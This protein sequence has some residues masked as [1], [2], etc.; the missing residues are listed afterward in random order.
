MSMYGIFQ[1]INLN[2]VVITKITD[3]IMTFIRCAVINTKIT[4]DMRK[5]VVTWLLTAEFF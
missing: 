4:A 2:A 3:W 1:I 5:G